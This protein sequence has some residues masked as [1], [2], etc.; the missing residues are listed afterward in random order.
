MRMSETH[1]RAGGKA[2]WKDWRGRERERDARAAKPRQE[3]HLLP[4][5]TE[6]ASPLTA[7]KSS[8]AGEQEMRRD[9]LS[10]AGV[11]KPVSL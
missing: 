10:A 5:S 3:L 4:S 1:S 2:K 8:P 9:G 6:T 7:A 11:E